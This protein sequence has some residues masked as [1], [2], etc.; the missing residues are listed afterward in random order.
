MQPFAAVLSV[1][2]MAAASADGCPHQRP[3]VARSALCTRE[4]IDC[5]RLPMLASRAWQRGTWRDGEAMQISLILHLQQ[6]QGT[7]A[8]NLSF[9]TYIGGSAKPRTQAPTPS[10]GRQ[11]RLWLL[12]RHGQYRHHVRHH[13]H[14][15]PSPAGRHRVFPRHHGTPR[16]LRPAEGAGI[17]GRYPYSSTGHVET[18]YGS[19]RG[20]K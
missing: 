19:P 17:K 5:V 8:N 1:V 20:S 4:C 3:L 14:S 9:S 12:P 15:R 10:A 11:D 16:L 6:Q 2:G 7:V 13:L 18:V